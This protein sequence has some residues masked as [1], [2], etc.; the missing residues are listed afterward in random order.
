MEY[1]I[2]PLEPKDYPKIIELFKEFA[3]FE[4]LPEKMTNSVSQIENDKELFNCFIA[5]TNN[6]IIGY[7]TYFYAYYSWIG[8]SLYLDD[9]Y[10]TQKHRNKGLGKKLLN[11]VI[12]IAKENNCKKVRWQVSSWNKNAQNFYKNIG[13]EIDNIELNCDLIL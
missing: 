11:I 10:V 12:N 6:T 13:A 7:T 5:E 9:L 3:L 4:K 2:R 1:L 8:K